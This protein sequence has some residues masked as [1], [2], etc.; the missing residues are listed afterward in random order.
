MK[1][2]ISIFCLVLLFFTYSCK[3]T[4]EF[5]DVIY[6]TGTEETN[7]V[8]F[9][10]EGPSSMGLTVTA[11]DI[12]SADTKVN[13]KIRP[14]LIAGLNAKTSKNYVIPPD[15][16]YNL[17]AD[18]VIIRAG[19]HISEQ[20]VFNI[21]ATDGFEEGS[22]YC[23]PVS[24]SGT[25]GSMPVL[26][27][28]RTI[29][30]LIRKTIITKA[31]NLRKST[32]F[33][34]PSFLLNPDVSALPGL[35]MECRVL[36]NTFH[37]SNPFISSII[38]IE[39]KF[40][41]RFGDVSIAKDQIMLAGGEVTGAGKYQLAAPETFSAGKWYHVAAVYT[42]SA[43][44]LYVDGRM[45]AST[46][47]AK[48]VIDFSYDWA[49]GFHIGYSADG[50]KLD[51]YVSEARIWSKALT[52]SQLQE[53]LC[54]VDPTSDGLVAY[55]RFNDSDGRNVTDLTG[56][57]YTAVASENITWIEGIKCP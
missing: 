36:A 8:S 18:N 26:E 12:V 6:I 42:G 56:H 7:T 19:K 10:I 38:G 40:L 50:R 39:E 29:Y 13:L 14:E 37:G 34:V 4:A 41:L 23:I 15:G 48:G 54:Y 25:D 20:I 5:P 24:I 43:M 46:E 35:T 17:S 1:N 51:G 55:W 16:S 57:G 2:I 49:G 21:T 31:V 28:S 32:Y 27:P 44:I 33:T 53:N 52:A 22:N 9:A 11:S 3:D 47:A 45:V 30:I